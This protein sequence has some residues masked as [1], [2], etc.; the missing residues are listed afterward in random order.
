MPEETLKVGVLLDAGSLQAWQATVLGSVLEA[1]GLRLQVVAHLTPSRAPGAAGASP[2]LRS[3][4]RLDRRLFTKQHLDAFAPSEPPDL[5]AESAAVAITIE[6]RAPTAEPI[7]H[8]LQP[9]ALDVLLAL[10]SPPDP[11]VLAPLA[12]Y[13]VWWFEHGHDH[14]SGLPGLWEIDVDQPATYGAIR[15]LRAGEAPT[16]VASTVSATH[17]YSVF[18]TQNHAYWKAARL[19]VRA[20]T[21]L[22]QHGWERLPDG[23]PPTTVPPLAA[24]WAPLSSG[25]VLTLVGR[26]LTR[27]VVDGLDRNLFDH[28]WSIVRRPHAPAP[29]DRPAP[30]QR[31]IDPAAG[32]SHADPFP[33]EVD[34][35][36]HL[37]FEQIRV[38]N[39]KGVIAHATIGADG[40]PTPAR[41][42]IDEPFH[43]SYPLVFPWRGEW[44]M[45]PEMRQAGRIDLYRAIEFPF[46]WVREQTLI[47][48]CRASDPTLVEH[49]GRVWLFAAVSASGGPAVDELC[50]Y[51]ADDIHGPWTPHPKNP[52]V[53]DVRTARPAGRFLR[54]AEGLIRPGQDCSV[55]YGYRV[56]LNRIHTLTPTEYREA[57]C[58]TVGPDVLPGG[59]A[60]HTFNVCSGLEWSD[61]L[62]RSLRLPTFLRGFR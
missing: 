60:C 58:G 32:W 20:L 34:G 44:Y 13:G 39:G 15:A 46:R 25:R 59:L 49:E 29:A 18:L 3:Y 48:D 12:R 56:S 54:D 61:V 53:T 17:R 35:T 23:P 41:T 10:G 33:I 36:T 52:I 14:K 47:A 43:V 62:Q 19:F 7:R 27:Y 51:Y 57:P 37:F 45:M 42:V 11:Q 30:W 40:R 2:L 6:D 55:R 1:D 16:V 38:R 8:A 5:G 4:C 26:V 21:A 22:A 28:R 50:A 9:H 31:L 24:S